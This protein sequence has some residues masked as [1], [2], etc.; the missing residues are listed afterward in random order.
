MPVSPRIQKVEDIL[1]FLLES[2]AIEQE[3]DQRSLDLAI[4]AW[5][6]IVPIKRLDHG[7]IL[8]THMILMHDHPSKTPGHY[9]DGDVVVAQAGNVI[10]RPP[11]YGLVSG[12]MAEWIRD[13]N[14]LLEPKADHVRFETIHPFWDGNGRMGRILMNWQHVKRNERIKIIYEKDKASYYKWFDT[15]SVA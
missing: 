7:V 9:R 8:Q 11:S 3:Y 5:D 15:R 1:H 6:Y 14:Q 12:L 13:A 4:K 2:N 10:H